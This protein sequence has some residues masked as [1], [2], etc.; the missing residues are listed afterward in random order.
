MNKGIS[1]YISHDIQTWQIDAIRWMEIEYLAY[2]P[3]WQRGVGFGRLQH[4]VIGKNKSILINYTDNYGIYTTEAEIDLNDEVHTYTKTTYC[5]IGVTTFMYFFM[6][7]NTTYN[8]LKIAY[9]D[10]NYGKHPISMIA[11]GGCNKTFTLLKSGEFNNN[12]S[13]YR[14]KVSEITGKHK[15]IDST[16]LAHEGQFVFALWP[17]PGKTGHIS[18]IIGGKEAPGKLMYEFAKPMTF[19]IGSINGYMDLDTGF[20]DKKHKKDIHFYLVEKE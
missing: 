13:R 17:N 7:Y 4:N 20:Y 9:G 18:T 16:K 19:N 10:K 5:N 14:I 12:A 11:Q 8:K 2:L 1:T 3:A 6:G 15:K